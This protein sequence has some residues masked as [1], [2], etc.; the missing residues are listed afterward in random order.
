MKVKIKEGRGIWYLK[1]CF[2]YFSL[3]KL[4]FLRQIYYISYLKKYFYSYSFLLKKIT[5]DE[6]W[7]ILADFCISLVTT[8]AS[9]RNYPLEYS[10]LE[11]CDLF[12]Q[13]NKSL[14]LFVNF[15]KS[16]F[17][18]ICHLFLWHFI[19]IKVLSGLFCILGKRV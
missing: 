16:L 10:N 15:P 4:S 11:P 3:M 2:E 18:G 12:L 6:V 13:A 8:P 5:V 7:A 14:E 9:E 17:I 1:I 19:Y